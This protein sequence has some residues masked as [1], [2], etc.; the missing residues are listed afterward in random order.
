MGSAF[1][2]E[3][4]LYPWVRDRAFVLFSLADDSDDALVCHHAHPDCALETPHR[5][6]AC[7]R[8]LPPRPKMA[9]KDRP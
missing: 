3:A 4:Q 9:S 6:H 2:A 5:L 1:Y 7:G 8:F